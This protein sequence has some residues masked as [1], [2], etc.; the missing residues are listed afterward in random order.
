MQFE[1]M[2]S[3]FSKVKAK[4]YCLKKKNYKFIKNKI[5]LVKLIAIKELLG[6]YLTHL[7][8]FPHF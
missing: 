1:K 3:K 7:F 6:H 5:I 4:E 8:V 2:N